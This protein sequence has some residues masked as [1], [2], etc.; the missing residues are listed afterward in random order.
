M[1]IFVLAN[2][3]NYFLTVAAHFYTKIV[4]INLFRKINLL[5]LRATEMHY[6]CALLIWLF[7]AVKQVGTNVAVQPDRSPASYSGGPTMKYRFWYQMF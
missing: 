7:T 4:H 5:L 3:N 6:K 2:S 1:S